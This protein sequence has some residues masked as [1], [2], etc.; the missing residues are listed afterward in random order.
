MEISGLIPNF[1]TLDECPELERRA[2][3]IYKEKAGIT[4]L[5]LVESILEADDV[6]GLRAAITLHYIKFDTLAFIE[7]TETFAI[8]GRVMHKHVTAVF[9]L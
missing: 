3:S 4:Q 9:T 1:R 7:R 5:I 8:N 6:R 2:G